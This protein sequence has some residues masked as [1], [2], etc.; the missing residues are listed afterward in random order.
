MI[1][2][3]YKG[4]SNQLINELKEKGIKDLKVLNALS[5]VP[6][7]L[8][9]DLVFRDKFSYQDIAF[10]I[11]EGQT[12]SQPYTVA[13]QS[14]L[15]SVKRGDKI[16]EIGT[17]SG[18]QAAVL[19][20]LGAK[21]F[22]IERHKALFNNAKLFLSQKNYRAQLFFGDG[23]KGKK[24]FSPFDSIIVTCGAPYV[25]LE[26]KSQLKIGGKIVIPV[27]EGD[28]QQMKLILRLDKEN[29]KETNFGDFKF[30]PML[31]RIKN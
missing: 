12:I 9:F 26:L 14:E 17:G 1:E 7:H 2:N 19:C 23:F 27:G 15:L 29:F 25:P 16:L 21:V 4:L 31:K 20:E 5:R 13:F 30:V 10:P 6:R 18:Y 11:G 22:S 3:K 8:L 28:V 24:A